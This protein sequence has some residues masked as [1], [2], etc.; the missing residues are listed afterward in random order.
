MLRTVLMTTTATLAL[1]GTASAQIVAE[2]AWAAQRALYE[3]AGMTVTAD[4]VRDGDTLRIDG[5]T[6]SADLPMGFGSL[7]FTLGPLSMTD[8]PDG[9]VRIDGFDSMDI[10]VTATIGSA[11]IEP[12]DLLPG[13]GGTDLALEPW[14]MPPTVLAG[15]IAVRSD[16]LTA[17]A[18][19]TP[20]DVTFATTYGLLAVSMTEGYRDEWS[21]MAFGMA[22]DQFG[23][24]TTHRITVEDGGVRSRSEYVSERA[25]IDAGVIESYGLRSRTY[26]ETGSATATLEAFFPDGGFDILNLGPALRNGMI[27]TGSTEIAS[28]SAQNWSGWD[29]ELSLTDT[30]TSGIQRQDFSVSA[31]G[32]E[33]DVTMQDLDTT[34]A[35][36]GF[37]PS[38]GG[39]VEEVRFGFGFPLLAATDGELQRARFAVALRNLTL[40]DSAWQFFDIGN[41][42]IRDP[43]TFD[44]AASADLRL[45]EDV[46]DVMRLEEIFAQDTPPFDLVAARIDAFD[47]AFMGAAATGTGELVFD[48]D[49]DL[50]G[51]P[52]PVGSARVLITGL[53]GLIDQAE[54]MGLLLPA[55]IQSMRFGLAMFTKAVG[56]DELEARIEF[57]EDGRMLVNGNPM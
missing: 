31:A 4:T 3:T 36:D 34:L 40:D 32:I 41:M 50:F 52:Q 24:T 27:L 5:A 18:S 28:Y 37:M 7:S 14:P 55:D 6:F 11:M 17:V 20:G 48:A 35:G 19:G 26:Y 13:D 51:F 29:K 45:L 21:S 1:V 43:A 38:M 42:V 56:E 9:T 53:N 16:G 2:D 10:A 8:L 57:T 46:T 54:A 23:G 30:Q 44:V 25:I 47:I 22:Y 39:S 33:T 15:R 49:R 12:S